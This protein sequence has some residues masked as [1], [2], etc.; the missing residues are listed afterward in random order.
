MRSN[1]AVEI[2]LFAVRPAAAARALCEFVQRRIDSCRLATFNDDWETS[3][4][5]RAINAGPPPGGSVSMSRGSLSDAV[6][7]AGYAMAMSDELLGQPEPKPMPRATENPPD[8][9]RPASQTHPRETIARDRCAPSLHILGRLGLRLP[10]RLCLDHRRARRQSCRAAGPLARA[11]SIG[12]LV[13]S[14]FFRPTGIHLVG[15]C[16][17]SPRPSRGDPPCASS[18]PPRFMPRCPSPA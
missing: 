9:R 10:A 14:T 8:P 18:P 12:L 2:I 3:S 16:S 11:L 1:S 13:W 7:A 4:L 15:K 5:Q 6:R 17:K